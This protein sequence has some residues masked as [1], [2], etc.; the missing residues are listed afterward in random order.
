MCKKPFGIDARYERTIGRM[1]E[2]QPGEPW[3]LSAPETL[4]LLTGPET[5]DAVA[6]RVALL[7]LVVRRSLKLSLATDRRFL[8]FHPKVNVLSGG[9]AFTRRLEKP[10]QRILDL[11]PQLPRRT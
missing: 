11:F 10:L 5:G 7:E 9:S 2:R 3:T 8:I 1:V 4:V 6:L